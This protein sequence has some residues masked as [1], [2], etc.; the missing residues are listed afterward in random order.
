MTMTMKLENIIVKVGKKLEVCTWQIGQQWKWDTDGVAYFGLHLRRANDN[1]IQ[2]RHSIYPLLFMM[3][4]SGGSRF[5]V[6]STSVIRVSSYKGQLVKIL[7]KIG[8]SISIWLVKLSRIRV[9]NLHLTTTLFG[10]KIVSAFENDIS[11]FFSWKVYSAMSKL[12]GK[13]KS[14]Y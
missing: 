6:H 8:V 4:G 12:D 14:M 13:Y 7:A 2:T 1:R 3:H 9:T 10:H 5:D 11:W